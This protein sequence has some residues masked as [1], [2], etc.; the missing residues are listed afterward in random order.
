M[1]QLYPTFTKVE[2]PPDHV[3][4]SNM[5][6]VVCLKIVFNVLL[7]VNSVIYKVIEVIRSF[8]LPK[9]LLKM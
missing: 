3:S 8:V 9:T 6:R 4:W 2:S 7:S 1:L 5:V